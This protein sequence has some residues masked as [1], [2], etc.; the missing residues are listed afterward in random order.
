M[1]W[2]ISLPQE[3]VSTVLYACTCT[4]ILGVGH[5]LVYCYMNRT[6]MDGSLVCVLYMMCAGMELGTT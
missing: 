5:W 4:L 3:Q 6:L 1:L 2:I